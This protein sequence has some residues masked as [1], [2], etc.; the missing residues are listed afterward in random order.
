[1]ESASLALQR[2]ASSA[3]GHATV[4]ITASEVMGVR[5]LPPMLAGLRETHPRLDI[6]LSLSNQLEDL[7][8]HDADIAVR[9][10]RPAQQ[11]LLARQHRFPL[12]P[13]RPPLIDISAEKVEQALAE[14][15][16][17]GI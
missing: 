13:V 12:W 9:M 7:L 8:R 6:E 15:E 11:A 17:E 3:S 5:V 1:M 14:M 10:V 2:T 4:R 16:A